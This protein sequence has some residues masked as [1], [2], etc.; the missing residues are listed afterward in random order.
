MGENERIEKLIA[1]REERCYIK[2]LRLCHGLKSGWVSLSSPYTLART[3]PCPRCKPKGPVRV[4]RRRR[5]P[6][7][8]YRCLHCARVFNAWTGTAF[9]KTRHPPYKLLT[10]VVGVAMEVSTGTLARVGRV[11]RAWLYSVRKKWEQTTW[12]KALRQTGE[13]AKYDAGGLTLEDL[14]CENRE[15]AVQWEKYKNQI[16]ARREDEQ[17]T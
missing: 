8:D 4:H 3:P 15:W 9:Q 13:V 5:S 14:A 7:L 16:Q 1:K 6:V 12:L 10:L 17:P 2:L 11:Q